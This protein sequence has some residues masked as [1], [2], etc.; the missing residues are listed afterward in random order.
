MKRVTISHIL[1]AFIFLLLCLLFLK[2]YPQGADSWVYR[3][4]TQS[5]VEDTDLHL[6]NQFLPIQDKVTF[7]FTFSPT[8][9]VVEQQSPGV[10]F[11]Y[12][13][14]LYVGES[15]RLWGINDKERDFYSL[16]LADIFFGIIS[17][18]LLW[19]IFKVYLPSR[20]SLWILLPILFGT[21]I[22]YYAVIFTPSSHSAG[23]LFS[24]LF[25]YSF[26]HF[27]K[28]HTPL[29]AF[30]S[31][32][33][34]GT[35][36][37]IRP[38]TLLFGVIPFI[39]FLGEV[40]RKNKENFWQHTLPYFII[41]FGF[42]FGAFPLFLFWKITLG[43]WLHP[44][45]EWFVGLGAN[46]KDF[47]FSSFH[48]LFFY[49]PILLLLIFGFIPLIS[50]DKLLGVSLLVASSLEILI[51]SSRVSWWAG[52]SFGARHI[53]SSIPLYLLPGISLFIQAEKK[54]FTRVMFRAFLTLCAVWTFLLYAQWKSGLCDHMTQSIPS[55]VLFLNQF[56]VIPMLPHLILKRLLIHNLPLFL[57]PFILILS[58][59]LYIGMVG[60]KVKR[61]IFP[62]FLI[63][64]NLL[65]L[66]LLSL[67]G[68]NGKIIVKELNKEGFFLRY[69]SSLIGL[70]DKTNLSCNYAD[71][72]YLVYQKGM[73][74]Q[75]FYYLK[76]AEEILPHNPRVK[77]VMEK[78]E[79]SSQ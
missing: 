5:L 78:I 23:L 61:K 48:G 72:A 18:L 62:R 40:K 15:G 46:L 42:L 63:Y 38:D 4:Y 36:F 26:L 66:L 7:P 14:F 9:Y 21:G 69:P 47:L 8:G 10:S 54:R 44:Q 73:K 37:T 70:N 67:A 3:A 41:L 32:Y 22:F 55:S 77:Y 43:I 53:I 58:F 50:K 34:L 30:F 11:W 52:A 25:L 56:K 28:S 6:L 74:R 49:Y 2:N 60:G 27:R 57:I 16:N 17:F 76:K 45:S 75:A 79:K 12:I 64:Y 20:C 31:G 35:S 33:S 71:Y 68:F 29:F 39:F 65:L 13:P 1:P 59:L 51:L 19:K 24:S